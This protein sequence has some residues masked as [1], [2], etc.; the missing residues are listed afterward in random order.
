MFTHAVAPASM[1]HLF[2]CL[3]TSKGGKESQKESQKE[4][5]NKQEETRR[6]LDKHTDAA[7]RLKKGLYGAQFVATGTDW[8]P[9][10]QLIAA[11]Q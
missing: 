3:L 9:A 6:K 10:Y 1:C 8:S 11:G 5:T 2:E 7:W 4:E